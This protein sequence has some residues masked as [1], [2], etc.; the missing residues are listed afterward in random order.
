MYMKDISLK[1]ILGFDWDAGNLEKNSN[2]HGVF[3]WEC[4]QVFFNEPL[5]LSEDSKHSN[6]ENRI[7]VVGRTDDDRRLVI[8]VTVRNFLIR[9]ISA[10]DMNRKECKIYEEAK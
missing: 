8:I 6:H 7:Y 1:E 4:E 2:K 5:L 3:H 9:V 10:R